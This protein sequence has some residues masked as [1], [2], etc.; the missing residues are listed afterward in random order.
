MASGGFLWRELKGLETLWVLCWVVE[1]FAANSRRSLSTAVNEGWFEMGFTGDFGDVGWSLRL[2][3]LRKSLGSC[4]RRKLKTELRLLLSW[5][6]SKEQAP[7]P[8]CRVWSFVLLFQHIGGRRLETD[9]VSSVNI[10][11]QKPP[12]ITVSAPST[13]DFIRSLPFSVQ[14]GCQVLLRQIP[15]RLELPCQA[16]S[17]IVSSPGP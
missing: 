16:T 3:M 10:L 4:Y 1:D 7:T 14:I 11:N 6:V 5:K 15:V 13:H 8:C 17:V 9:A 2:L 12:S